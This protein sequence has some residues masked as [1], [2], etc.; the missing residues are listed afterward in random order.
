MKSAVRLL[1]LLLAAACV[2]A[3]APIEWSKNVKLT[4][5]DFRGKVPASAT[6][7]AHSWVGLDVAWE[8]RE[9]EARSHARAIF[10][11]DQS[12]WRTGTPS[13]W[14]GINEGLSRSQLENRRTAA[15]RDQDLLRHEQLHFDLTELSARKIRRQFEDLPRA[16]ATPAGDSRISAAIL[17]IER[18]WTDEQSRYDNDTDHGANRVTQRPWELR[19]LRQL[20]R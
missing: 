7:A 13:I 19:V 20:E 2:Y 6:D 14:G 17:D 8:C 3:A 18:A 10:D 12:W 11:P 4:Q 5:R 9:G 16:C 15:E 1:V